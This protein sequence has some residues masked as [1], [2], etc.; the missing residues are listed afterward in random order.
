MPER[1]L[2]VPDREPINLSPSKEAHGSS[3]LP[4]LPPATLSLRPS[5]LPLCTFRPL[6]SSSISSL[7][8]QQHIAF[9]SRSYLASP[10][11]RSLPSFSSPDRTA[12]PTFN[13]P[14]RS[15]TLLSLTL[16]TT[17]FTLATRTT[18]PDSPTLLS[19]PRDLP[20]FTPSLPFVLPSFPSGILFR[21]CKQPLTSASPSPEFY[22]PSGTSHH[23]AEQGPRA[24]LVDSQD[25]GGSFAFSFSPASSPA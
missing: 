7:F 19:R 8:H 1:G 14:C 21:S 20:S 23:P 3:L 13:S 18:S 12:S 9:T 4:S 10:P 11:T 6:I 22:L 17:S 2:P 16:W 5:H 25:Q 24:R 15:C